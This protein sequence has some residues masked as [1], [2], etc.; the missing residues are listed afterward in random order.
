MFFV[1]YLL[2]SVSNI[3]NMIFLGTFWFL[4][5]AAV[6]IS[7]W[8]NMMKW[9]AYQSDTVQMSQHQFSFQV[10]CIRACGMHALTSSG[11]GCLCSKPL[12]PCR[13]W[14]RVKTAAKLT[15][16]AVQTWTA[17]ANEKLRDYNTLTR[18]NDSCCF[19]DVWLIA[20][21]EF[22][23]FS[24]KCVCAQLSWLHSSQCKLQLSA[25]KK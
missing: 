10:P 3:C 14:N 18:V 2:N 1:S 9:K 15:C 16:S 23:C 21:F 22:L 6:S 8:A 4:I 25:A 12:W 19:M 20:I 11:A 13:Y 7:T 5:L 24:F 17:D